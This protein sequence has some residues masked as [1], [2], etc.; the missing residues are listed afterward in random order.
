MYLCRYVWQEQNIPEL[1]SKIVLMEQ[2]TQS[3]SQFKEGL[4]PS[5]AADLCSR[6]FSARK[7]LSSDDG[8]EGAG[9][10]RWLA[11]AGSSNCWIGPGLL[12][13]EI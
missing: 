11:G 8:A 12:I 5:L 9:S 3:P 7:S 2:R 1:V 4:G 6:Y 13:T 10:E